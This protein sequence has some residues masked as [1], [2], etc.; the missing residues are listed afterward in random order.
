VQVAA[1]APAA[2]GRGPDSPP[3]RKPAGMSLPM[4]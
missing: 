4:A 3:A 2:G 1:T